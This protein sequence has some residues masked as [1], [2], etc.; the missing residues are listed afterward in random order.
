MA[1]QIN[2][3]DKSGRLNENAYL[4]IGFGAHKKFPR[5]IQIY[6]YASAQAYQYN[7]LPIDGVQEFAID[8]ADAQEF[9]SLDKQQIEGNDIIKLGYE[10]LKSEERLSIIPIDFSN[11]EDA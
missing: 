1:L 11:A 3:T 5:V 6:I 4:N 7:K 9:F 10:F 8:E 2:Y